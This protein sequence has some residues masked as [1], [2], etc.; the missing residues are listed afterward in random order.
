MSDTGIE[1]P[2]PEQKPI[3]SGDESAK[4]PKQKWPLLDMMI[5]VQSEALKRELSAR[6]IL[7]EGDAG[8]AA[9]IDREADALF[10]AAAVLETV[11]YFE[12]EFREFCRAQMAAFG[13]NKRGGGFKK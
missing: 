11:S 1:A 3:R 9:E 8:I 10:A 2:S 5:A 13:K 4:R 6:V 7:R 12:D